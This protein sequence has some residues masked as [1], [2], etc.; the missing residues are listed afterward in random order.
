LRNVKCVV[1]ADK[2]GLNVP[3]LL[4]GPLEE[5]IMTPNPTLA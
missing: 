1:E 4:L 2:F 3:E 5:D